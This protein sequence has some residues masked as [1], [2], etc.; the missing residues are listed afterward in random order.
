M[1]ALFPKIYDVIDKNPTKHATLRWRELISTE[2]SSEQW[3]S[4]CV[5]PLDPPGALSLLMLRTDPMYELGSPSLRKQILTEQLLV[6]HTRVDKE[7]VGRRYPR[8]KIQDL[9]AG[10]ISAQS[11]ASSPLLEEV[12]CELFQVQKILID[13]RSKTIQ[14]S[15]PDPRLWKS[16]RRLVFSE[17]DNC[18][19]FTPSE[20]ISLPV[21]LQQK[22]QEN[23]QLSWPT[24]DGKFEDLKAILVAKHRL[25]EGKV[26]KDELAVL[27]GRLQSLDCLT[28][29]QLKTC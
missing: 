10:Q 18:W 4:F 11:P 27:V 24:A 3:E 21:W 23:W 15:P 8:K 19:S 17:P 20:S 13:R 26:K 5:M 12:L 16:D 2:G 9:L 14:F 28:E 25:P 7:L 22:E 1:A 29:L 6:L